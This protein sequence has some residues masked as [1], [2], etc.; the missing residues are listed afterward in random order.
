MLCVYCPFAM[1]VYY[2][3]LPFLT[4]LT[5]DI[6]LL[7]LMIFAPFRRRTRRKSTFGLTTHERKKHQLGR[8]FV[9]RSS[10]DPRMEDES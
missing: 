6:V 8:C 5:F 3:A 9:S 7:Y 2:F 1:I 4:I 10:S